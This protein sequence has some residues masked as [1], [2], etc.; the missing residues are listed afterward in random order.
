MMAGYL[1]RRVE[2]RKLVGTSGDGLEG[3]GVGEGNSL[4]RLGARSTVNG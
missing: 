2:R 3:L 4:G 1:D